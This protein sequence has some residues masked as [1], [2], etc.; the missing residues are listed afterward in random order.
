MSVN[1]GIYKPSMLANGFNIF[2]ILSGF[3]L[4]LFGQQLYWLFVGLIGFL[5]GFELA[6]AHVIE[7]RQWLAVLIAAGAGFLGI[8][9]ALFAHRFFFAVIGFFVVGYAAHII[10]SMS[11]TTNPHIQ[12]PV[13]VIAGIIGAL[14][15]S[16]LLDPTLI[17][18]SSLTGSLIIIRS[19][20]VDPRL[21]IIIFVLLLVF[22]SWF[23]LRTY[24]SPRHT[25]QPGMRFRP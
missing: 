22:G 4:L 17:L 13:L 21:K 25:G 15:F 8:F 20:T 9:F 23:Q 2:S 12:V 24:I 5:I 18:I 11:H 19:F 10:L 14:L 6:S 3:V 1:T 7:Q 16:L